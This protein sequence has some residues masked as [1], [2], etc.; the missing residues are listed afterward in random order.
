MPLRDPPQA[1]SPLTLPPICVEVWRGDVRES[2]HR[3]HAVMVDEAGRALAIA[4]DPER[5]TSARSTIA[6][7]CA[8]AR[9]LRSA[10]FHACSVAV[11]ASCNGAQPSPPPAHRPFIQPTITL[12]ELLIFPP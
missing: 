9:S 8:S 2:V 10:L 11:W 6:L 1:H 7:C 3:A 12:P 5:L 4:G